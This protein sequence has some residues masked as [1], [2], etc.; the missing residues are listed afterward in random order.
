MRQVRLLGLA[1]LMCHL[2]FEAAAQDV[3][4]MEVESADPVV[5]RVQRHVGVSAGFPVRVVAS[6]DM[7]GDL[8]HRVKHLV[9]FRI[10][11]HMSD[12][13]TEVDPSIY[14]VRTSDIYAKAAA[15]IRNGTTNH[16]YVWCL[17]AAVLTHEAAHTHP[18]TEQQALAA[19]A[20][21]LRR[22]LFAGHLYAADGW[23]A[24]TYLGKVE[25]KR[26]NPRE[27]Y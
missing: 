4:T 26:R 6:E 24:V 23:S 19:E 7:P 18:R 9:A 10:H 17:L 2:A 8:W 11:R 21:Q 27:H 14:L 12:R 1:I 5:A 25:A 20:A 3:T 13:T 16:D 22:C 15:A